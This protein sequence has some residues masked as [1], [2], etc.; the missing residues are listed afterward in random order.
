MVFLFKK[1]VYNYV[2]SIYNGKC[3]ANCDALCKYERWNYQMIKDWVNKDERE[4]IDEMVKLI[5]SLHEIILSN[6]NKRT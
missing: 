6:C 3:D 1:S 4:P 5:L 2:I